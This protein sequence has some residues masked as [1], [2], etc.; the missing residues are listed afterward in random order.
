MFWELGT[1]KISEKSPFPGS[2]NLAD[3]Q[4]YKDLLCKQE[5]KKFHQD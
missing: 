1:L 4:T 3:L 2:F 5:G